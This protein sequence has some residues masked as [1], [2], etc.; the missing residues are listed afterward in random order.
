MHKFGLHL[1]IW[2]LYIFIFIIMWYFE[3]LSSREMCGFLRLKRLKLCTSVSQTVARKYASY[4][5]LGPSVHF[6]NIFLFSCMLWN[7]LLMYVP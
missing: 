4:G 5:A 6:D 3:T 1:L 2:T 7:D